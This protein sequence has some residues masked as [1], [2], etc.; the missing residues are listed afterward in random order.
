MK[1]RN[2]RKTKVI[3]ITPTWKNLVDIVIREIQVSNLS[4]KQLAITLLGDMAKILDN[5]KEE[6]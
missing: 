4:T 5:L 1:F 3:D 2:I 6:K